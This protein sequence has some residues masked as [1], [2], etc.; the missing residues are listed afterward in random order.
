[1]AI[2]LFIEI[3]RRIIYGGRK[4]GVERLCGEK[5]E[6]EESGATGK[7][8]GWEGSVVVGLQRSLEESG[9]LVSQNGCIKGPMQPSQYKIEA[10]FPF[11]V[12]ELPA[13]VLYDCRIID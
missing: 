13:H 10:T 7:Q 9:E 8:C 1:M 6:K 2:Y 3:E 4:M 5:W 11:V 12:F